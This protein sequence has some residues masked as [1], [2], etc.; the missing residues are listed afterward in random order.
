NIGA[1]PAGDYASRLHSHLATHITQDS[2]NRFVSDGEKNRWNGKA[3][4]HGHPYL[5]TNGGTVHGSVTVNGDLRANR[6]YNAVWNDY[7]EFFERGEETEVGDIIALDCSSDK[8]QYVKASTD[9]FV[10]V[11]VHSDSFAHLIGGKNTSFEENLNEFIP[12]GLAGRVKCKVIG[13]VYKGQYIGLSNLP[14]IGA[15][16][17]YLNPYIVG[18]ALEDKL[19]EDIGM[20]KILIK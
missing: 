15:T 7:A 10:V 19:T 16:V 8:E 14:G 6:V 17:D 4:A 3:D 2:N 9:N 13:K 20:I 1:Q 12:V 18:I 5:H 11:G